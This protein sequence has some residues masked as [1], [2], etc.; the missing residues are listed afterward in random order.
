MNS[1]RMEISFRSKEV[2]AALAALPKNVSEAVRKRVARRVMKPYV[3]TLAAAWL[4]ANF[5][6]PDA[7]HRMAVAAALEA[8]VRR[9]GAADASIIRTRLGVRYGSRAKAAAFAKGRQ[10]VWHLLEY[11]FRH[12]GSGNAAYRSPGAAILNQKAQARAFMKQQRD[13]MHKAFPGNGRRD[14]TE[15][16]RATQR[17]FAAVRQALPELAAYNASRKTVLAA[18]RAGTSV[19]SRVKGRYIS[20]RWGRKNLKPLMD[21]LAR[22]TL[23]EAKR[24]LGKVGSK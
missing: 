4:S 13:A 2:R 3:G 24:A 7:K 5:R 19:A 21:D 11:G 20:W 17:A 8:D 22:E 23:L 6:G 15:R 14:R 12:Y 10:K 9:V 18:L 16:A 1:T